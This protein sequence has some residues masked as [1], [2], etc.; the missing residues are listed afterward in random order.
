[1]NLVR[2]SNLAT[3]N[4]LVKRTLLTVAATA[5]VLALGAAGP[6]AAD[7]ARA[8]NFG[9]FAPAGPDGWRKS[10]PYPEYK[11]KGLS[12]GST[13]LTSYSNRNG[14]GSI[15]LEFKDHISKGDRTAVEN[16]KLFGDKSTMIK[17]LK[18]GFKPCGEKVKIAAYRIITGKYLVKLTCTEVPNDVALKMLK[19]I[20]YKAVAAVK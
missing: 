2:K 7:L 14:A 3:Q 12:K 20:D 19:S 9:A 10:G 17:G 1:M 4:R 8:K 18:A 6:A 11:E 15:N 5:T 13:S 16:P